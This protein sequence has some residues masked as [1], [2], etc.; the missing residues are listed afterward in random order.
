M[1]TVGAL[2]GCKG[3][4]GDG[5]P[6]ADCA[7]LED[8]ELDCPD[9]ANQLR[10][11]RR[12]FCAKSDGRKHGPAITFY[13]DGKVVSRTVY[14]GGA[15]HGTAEG[16]FPSGDK[17]FEVENRHGKRHGRET[18][19]REDGSKKSETSFKDGKQHGKFT[20]WFEDG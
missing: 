9:G 5:D 2:V 20:S 19:W 16:W 8:C 10:R 15:E 14:V 4:S 11:D 18:W 1:V 13:E 17:H 3:G 6:F 12:F 7:T